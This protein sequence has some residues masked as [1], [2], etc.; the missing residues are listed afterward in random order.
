MKEFLRTVALQNRRSKEFEDA[1]L[2]REL[3][4]KNFDDF[5][6]LWKPMLEAR[7]A[8][9]ESWEAAAEGDAQDSHW[10]W[11]EKAVDASTS[12]ADETYAIECADETQG[13]MLV[14]SAAFARLEIQRGREIVYIELIATAPWNRPRL[15]KKAA[16]YKG[17][18]RALIAEAINLSYQ[19]EFNGRLG[20][21]SLPQSQSWYRDV[22]QFTDMGY[23]D[24]K[25]MQYFEVTEAQAKAF[26]AND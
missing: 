25:G 18:G 21:H 11:A 7:R 15:V 20:L 14:T 16:R 1:Q 4:Q 13:L 26:L 19:L 10:H 8:D 6:Q 24:E 9:F 17:V 12:M 22:A 3:D 2:Y 23:D 5:E